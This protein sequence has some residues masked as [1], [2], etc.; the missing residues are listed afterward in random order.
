MKVGPVKTERMKNNSS[1]LREGQVY[2]QSGKVIEVADVFINQESTL[3]PFKSRVG[4]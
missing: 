3:G 2:S 1:R 4:H